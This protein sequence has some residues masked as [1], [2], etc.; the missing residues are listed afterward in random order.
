MQTGF[1]LVHLAQ[2]EIDLLQRITLSVPWWGG[3]LEDATVAMLP[4]RLNVPV[5]TFNYRDLSA[6]PILQFWLPG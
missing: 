6:F 1:V 5:W 3:S 4:G 2:D